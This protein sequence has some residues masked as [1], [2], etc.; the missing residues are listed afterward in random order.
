MHVTPGHQTHIQ[1]LIKHIINVIGII[2]DEKDTLHTHT[3]EPIYKWPK[4]CI[5]HLVMGYV[6]YTLKPTCTIHDTAYPS[7]NL[8]T[9]CKQNLLTNQ[10]L[11]HIMS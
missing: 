10:T 3:S 9:L 8:S 1:K 7:K 2:C 6:P 11:A 4:V 5:M